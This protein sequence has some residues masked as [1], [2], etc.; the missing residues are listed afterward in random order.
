MNTIHNSPYGEAFDKMFRFDGLVAVVAGGCGGI[1]SAISH[2]LAH[3]GATV[4]I[5]DHREDK[6]CECVE[7]IA[8]LGFESARVIF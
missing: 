1:G 7:N 2:G 3:F 4:V 5:A 6:A 8:G